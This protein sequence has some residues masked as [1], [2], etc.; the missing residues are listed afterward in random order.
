MGVKHSDNHESLFSSKFSRLITY[1]ETY[2]LV[3]AHSTSQETKQEVALIVAHELAHQ[4]F[5]NLVVGDDFSLQFASIHLRARRWNGGMTFGS[6]KISI[7]KFSDL[8]DVLLLF[9][10][11]IRYLDSVSRC[12]SCL[13]RVR[14]LDTIRF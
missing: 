14:Y 5:G 10:F 12:R 2:L 7:A 11:T 3:D 13:S 1:H 4:W 8:F 6:M 9:R